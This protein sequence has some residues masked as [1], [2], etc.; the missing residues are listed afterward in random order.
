MSQTNI[1]VE[2]VLELIAAYG[3][4]SSGWPEAEKEAAMML[5]AAQPDDFAVALADAQLIDYALE[6]EMIE[7]PSAQFTEQLLKGAPTSAVSESGFFSGLKA[8]LFPKGTRW[9]A[10]AALA[11]LAMGLVGG[12]AYAA[13]GTA[14]DEADQ[15][16]Y[17]AFGY[18]AETA[19]TS[20]DV[21]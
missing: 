5:V 14:Y 19:W 11:S 16:F 15:A 13:T 6:H 18:D 3:A 4:H 10:G 1:S 2:R 17:T 12:Y 9:P 20:E 8:A 7:L 21:S